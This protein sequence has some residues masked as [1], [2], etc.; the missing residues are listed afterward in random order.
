MQTYKLL[1]L[2]VPFA[3]AGPQFHTR[4]QAAE[5][6]VALARFHQQRVA[7]TKSGSNFCP[8]VCL[9]MDFVR[10]QI[11]ARRS[12]NALAIQHRH[13]WHLVSLTGSR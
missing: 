6:L 10:C 9:H 12:I 1:T 7:P 8:D 3:F 4:D 13:R 5:V 11:K 2:D